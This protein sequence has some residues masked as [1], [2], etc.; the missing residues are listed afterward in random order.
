MHSPMAPSAE[1]FVKLYVKLHS[2]YFG[3]QV[4]G[5]LTAYLEDHISFLIAQFTRKYQSWKPY[6]CHRW[7]SALNDLPTQIFLFF[8][9]HSDSYS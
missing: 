7:K 1:L 6:H 4:Q 2:A 3:V 8:Y 9:E 5:T